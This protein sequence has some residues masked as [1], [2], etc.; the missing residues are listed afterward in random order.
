MPP[1][2]WIAMRLPLSRRHLSRRVSCRPATMSF[3]AAIVIEPEPGFSDAAIEDEL[4]RR[5]LREPR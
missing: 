1:G 3:E 4:V 5:A 2:A